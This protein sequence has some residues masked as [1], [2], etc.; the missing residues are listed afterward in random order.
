MRKLKQ[1][2]R[3]EK[4]H[5][6][7][8]ILLFSLIFLFVLSS[9]GCATFNRFTET[10]QK[11]GTD[12]ETIK[13]GV[14]EPLTGEDA[15]A[16]EAE[17]KG[18]ELAHELYPDVNGTKVELL[19]GDTRSEIGFVGTAAQELIDKGIVLAIGSYGN[20]YSLA[21]G[22]VFQKAEIP[23]IGATC[24]NPL[25]T[26]GNPY[27]FRVCIVDS[28]QG[29]MAAKY[30]YN[31]LD[32]EEAVILKQSG[33]DYATEL[34]QKFS[35]K[36]TAMTGE[37]DAVVLTVEYKKGTTDFAKQLETIQN[38]DAEAVYLP[39]TASDA[40]LIIKQAR[41]AGMENV[42]LGS[43]R[44]YQDEL[45]EG[46]ADAADGLVFTTFSDVETTLS[47]NTQTYL[48]AYAKKYG[49]EV[50]P[51]SE[52]A[53]GFDAYL[54]AINAMKRQQK[55]R[56]EAAETSEGAVSD[57]EAKPKTLRDVLAATKEFQ[58]ATGSL[59]F[60]ESGDPIKPVVFMT[61]QN[62]EFTYK[63]TATPEWGN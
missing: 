46:A 61:V 33:D 30:V 59:A 16:A 58:G 56:E 39:C 54:L 17:I 8:E 47:I 51:E 37:T 20:T 60:G 2:N 31:D 40:V 50:T 34:S 24:A 11:D 7:R 9:T 32:C 10:I 6:K 63:Y 23:I 29:T 12:A 28:F 55:E 5:G 62:G 4:R 57:D 52:T 45:L 42:F 38:A 53:L 41:E 15:A 19:Y 3:I 26:A 49:K 48:D 35:D 18:I 13:I 36:M 44:W 25:V 21:A 27:Y 22:A 1:T 14:L 43:E